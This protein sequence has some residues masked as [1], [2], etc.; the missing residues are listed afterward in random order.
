MTPITPTFNATTA[1]SSVAPVG[2]ADAVT[3]TINGTN[4]ETKNSLLGINKAQR[5]ASYS[6]GN[7]NQEDNASIASMRSANTKRLNKNVLGS[8][9]TKAIRSTQPT[10]TVAENKSKT[11]PKS[12]FASG[13]VDAS[14]RPNKR[15]QFQSRASSLPNFDTKIDAK[16]GTKMSNIHA[17]LKA[18][19]SVYDK[20]ERTSNLKQK[21][22]NKVKQAFNTQVAW[23]NDN[24]SVVTNTTKR[25]KIAMKTATPKQ[26]QS[27]MRRKINSLETYNPEDDCS[28]LSG[29]ESVGSLTKAKNDKPWRKNM[30]ATIK[31]TEIAA[32]TP[33]K[34]S[35]PLQPQQSQ[36]QHQSKQQMEQSRV[37][38]Q[39]APAPQQI[40]RQ[41][42]QVLQPAVSLV[43]KVQV[44]K[45][46]KP[47]LLQV[48]S[49]SK[50]N[51]NAEN[52][53]QS[54][55]LFELPVASSSQM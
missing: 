9:S 53:K 6:R 17:K 52:V 27:R 4:V 7:N 8:K 1:A 22:M 5:V 30:K 20:P 12:T 33:H 18:C 13:G 36:Q 55:E 32:E 54:V 16:V 48:K 3:A 2:N 51:A 21:L 39:D 23:N 11:M 35:Q 49:N 43:P 26:P 38:V 25:T 46:R 19:K 50:F 31:K 24:N 41:P 40:R 15:L 29:V 10:A 34:Q 28:L 42:Q 47:L 37:S 14:Q 45:E 44:Q